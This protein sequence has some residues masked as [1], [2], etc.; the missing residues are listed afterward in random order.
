MIFHPTAKL[1]LAGIL[2]LM[3]SSVSHAETSQEDACSPCQEAINDLQEAYSNDPEF[4]KLLT[5]A[6][7]NMQQLPPEYPG[8]NPWIGKGLPDLVRFLSE[9]CTFL[10]TI[11]G[12]RDT[13]LKFIQD[14]AWFYYKNEYGMRFVKQSP[15]RE[16]MQDFARQRGAFMDSRASSAEIANWLKDAGIEKEDYNL[17]DPSSPD[18]GFRSFNEFFARTLKNQDESRPQTMPDRDYVI[19]APTD[20]IM[21]SIPQ[22]I[23]DANTVI[24]TKFR[25]AL[26]IHDMLDGSKYAEKFIGGTAL[27]C[28]L[29]PNTYHHYHSPVGGRVVETG[30]ISDAFFG[31]EDF[32]VWAPPNGNVGYYGTDFS[33]FENFQ[34]GYFIVDT[35]KYGHVALIA[36]GLDTIS[37]IVFRERFLNVTKP[38]PVTRGEA[39]GHFLY[40]GSL[41]IMVFEPDRYKAGAIKVRLGNQ[42]G[43][44]DTTCEKASGPE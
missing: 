38:V 23:G 3:I 43:V 44:F 41:F 25:Q 12:G 20:C 16:I 6:F 27:S 8:G 18:G 19:S 35:G 7:G 39:L 2:S 32:P 5:S 11:E 30:I 26:N 1:I 34:R 15:G 31:Y 28:V 21:N 9:W 42:I 24:P 14:F 37:S 13:G 10:P 36:V 17:P 29:M 4:Q 22:K 33:E 40:G